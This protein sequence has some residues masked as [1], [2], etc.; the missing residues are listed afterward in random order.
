[1]V[2]RCSFNRTL[3]VGASCHSTYNRFFGSHLSGCLEKSWKSFVFV[4][5]E[6]FPWTSKDLM[7]CLK[8]SISGFLT[9]YW[10][11]DI[12]LLPLDIQIP[13]DWVLTSSFW[14]LLGVPNSH[15]LTFRMTGAW[16]HFWWFAPSPEAN[17]G[18]IVKPMVN[19]PLI[20]PYFWVG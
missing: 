7:R 16:L 3:F 11:L 9:I 8:P 5:L 14:R 12:F 20:R 4:F 19:K 18:F 13:W 6:G 15:L 2:W 17:I 10:F 1:M